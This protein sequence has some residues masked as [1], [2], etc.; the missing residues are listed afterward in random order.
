MQQHETRSRKELC[1]TIRVFPDDLP[2]ILSRLERAGLDH[3]EVPEMGSTGELL[4]WVI[5][6]GRRQPVLQLE[7]SHG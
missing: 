7:V 2:W 3:M 5:W 6:Y 4:G 1:R